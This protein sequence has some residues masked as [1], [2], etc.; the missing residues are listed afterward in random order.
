MVYYIEYND[1][2]LNKKIL[3]ER[4]NDISKL[5]KDSKYDYDPDFGQT[6]SAGGILRAI[7]EAGMLPPDEVE[8]DDD[9]PTYDGDE[10]HGCVPSTLTR[11]EEE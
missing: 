8:H 3:I 11:W 7:E 10:C 2:Q 6:I 5:T 1:I 4:L 9:C